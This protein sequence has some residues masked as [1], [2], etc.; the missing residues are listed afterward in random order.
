MAC[1]EK[2]ITVDKL[3]DQIHTILESI[4]IDVDFK[5]WVFE[6]IRENYNSE[7][8]AREKIYNSTVSGI[9]SEEKRLQNLTNMLLDELIDKP[10][11]TDKKKEIQEQIIVL[12]EKRDSI[13]LTGQKTLETTEQIFDFTFNL[14]DSFNNGSLQRKK[15]MISSIGKNFILKD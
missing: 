12:K 11:F 10:G 5:K 6:A 2:C 13:D 1:T 9:K 3:E 7:F 14:T 4:E 8:E 15:D